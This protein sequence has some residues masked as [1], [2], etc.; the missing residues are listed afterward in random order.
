MQHNA[1]VDPRIGGFMLPVGAT[2]N[3]DGTALYM[4]VGSIFIAQI[5]NIPL[6]IGDTFTIW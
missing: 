3:M 6:T 2:I 1:R 4:A 5:N